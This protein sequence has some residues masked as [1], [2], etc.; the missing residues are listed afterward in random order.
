MQHPLEQTI[1]GERERWASN[2]AIATRTLRKH[3]FTVVQDPL[4]AQQSEDRQVRQSHDAACALLG[5]PTPENVGHQV[6]QALGR[7][8]LENGAMALH[9]LN[10]RGHI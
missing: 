8:L 5:L 2:L 3:G 10:A 6:V 7:E 9:Q 1:D 4:A